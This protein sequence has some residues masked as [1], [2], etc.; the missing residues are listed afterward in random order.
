MKTMLIVDDDPLFLDLVKEMS[1]PS[2]GGWVIIRAGGVQRR[3]AARA[4]GEEV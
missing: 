4:P 2:P 3:S 1:I